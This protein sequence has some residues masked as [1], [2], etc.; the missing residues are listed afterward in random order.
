M[1]G[2][3][4]FGSQPLDASPLA[5]PQLCRCWQSHLQQVL[6]NTSLQ[7]AVTSLTKLTLNVSLQVTP[8]PIHL[9]IR[10]NSKKQDTPFLSC[11]KAFQVVAVLAAQRGFRFPTTIPQSCLSL[12][13]I[14]LLE[15]AHH[16]WSASPEQEQTF[17]P[18]QPFTAV[19]FPKYQWPLASCWLA[20]LSAN[21]PFVLR[22][23]LPSSLPCFS[24]S[25]IPLGVL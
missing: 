18:C 16:W 17:F 13:Q 12:C 3:C 25:F 10:A 4:H 21:I 6:L 1:A 20:H 5:H 9:E 7:E 8:L 22:T 19:D 2:F 15:A 11:L 23:M 14:T 24:G